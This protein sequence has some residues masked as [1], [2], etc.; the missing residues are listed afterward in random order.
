[1]NGYSDVFIRN[2]VTNQ[3]TLISRNADGYSANGYSGDA[4]ISADGNYVAFTS[5]A[6]TLNAS[7]PVSNS[8]SQIFRWTLGTGAIELVST[9]GDGMD[10]GNHHSYYPSISGDG[11]KISYSSYADNLVSSMNDVN[12]NLDVFVWDATSATNTLVSHSSG[13][14][15]TTANGYSP[16]ESKISRDGTVVVYLSTVMI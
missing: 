5:S 15:L 9:S 12:G 2:R 11:S 3:T 13:D 7:G 1:M 10:P 16:Y 6:T 4:V 14:A 8:Y